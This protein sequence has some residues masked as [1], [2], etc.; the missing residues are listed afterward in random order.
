MFF[1]MTGAAV[2]HFAIGDGAVLLVA[3]IVFTGL[4]VAF[5]ALRPL[6]RRDELTVSP[7]TFRS[8]TIAYWVTTWAPRPRVCSG[9]SD[10]RAAT[11]AIL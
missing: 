2:S 6:A 3:P 9:R 4:T 1:S 10:G 8:R 7:A 11:T 5:W